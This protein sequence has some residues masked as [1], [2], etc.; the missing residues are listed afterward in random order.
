MLGSRKLSLH[1]LYG[2]CLHENIMAVLN[3]KSGRYSVTNQNLIKNTHPF[4]H[5]VFQV[6]KVINSCLLVNIYKIQPP[7]FLFL[8]V[9]TLTFRLLFYLRTFDYSHFPLKIQFLYC[10]LSSMALLGSP[11]TP[12]PSHGRLQ[13]EIFKI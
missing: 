10:L 1:H 4:L 6:L 9:V 12:R 7:D 11:P 3:L 2:K 13:G 8:I 5:I